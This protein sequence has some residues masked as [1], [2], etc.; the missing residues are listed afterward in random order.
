MRL[1]RI[2]RPEHVMAG[3]APPRH[4]H[5]W[6]TINSLTSYTSREPG[7]A[8]AEAM[9]TVRTIDQLAGRILLEIEY[10]GSV[11]SPP[12]EE[13]PP[14]WAAFPHHRSSREF[15][16]E[17]AASLASGALEVPS[18]V[19]P[20]RNVILNQLHPDF[21][22]ARVVEQHSLSHLVR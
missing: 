16:D 20:G 21:G 12:V 2:V 9:V 4:D 14:Q 6:S 19:L 3:L 17:W 10:T 15:G 5:R 11:T 13:L 1:W 7:I 18:A 8:F 22:Q